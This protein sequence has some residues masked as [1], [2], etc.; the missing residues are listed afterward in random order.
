MLPAS[1]YWVLLLASCAY[2]L[3][4][5]RRDE[6]IAATVCL[7]GSIGSSF[8]LSPWRMRYSNVEFGLAAIDIIALVI[9]TA[10]ALRSTRFW[11]LWV[12]GLQ[13]TTSVAHLMKAVELDL[14]PQA[15]AAALR[16]WIYPILLIIVVGTWRSGRMPPEREAAPSL[17]Q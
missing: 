8:V 9:F 12:A 1:L 14:M 5:G 11:P 16:F 10:V 4:Q 13:L 6:R 15:Y 17:T 3:W 2:A 7:L